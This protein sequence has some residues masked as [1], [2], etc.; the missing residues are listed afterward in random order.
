MKDALRDFV[1]E[2]RP[3]FDDKEPSDKVWKGI[4]SELKS[5]SLWNSLVVWRIA[6]A[7]LVGLS[8]YL[9]V[10][11]ETADLRKKEVAS[12]Q[13]EFNDLE[14]FYSNQ[15]AEKVALISGLDESGEQ[16]QFTQDFQKLE[17][18]YQVLAEEMKSRPN[19][20]VKDA[21]ILNLLIRID[22]LNQQLKKLEDA[23]SK[24]D[25]TSPTEV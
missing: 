20:K 11:K 13:I 14:S 6:A 2:N 24:T 10:G 25:K 1:G 22:L 21:L 9:F 7:L 12:L 5:P 23:G 16:Q 4:Q 8:A 18:M 3:A 17:A 15:I 19:E